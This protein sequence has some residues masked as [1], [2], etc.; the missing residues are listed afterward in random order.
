MEQGILSGKQTPISSLAKRLL[1]GLVIVAVVAFAVQSSPYS[2][3]L[4]TL[5]LNYLATAEYTSLVQKLGYSLQKLLMLL[6]GMIMIVLVWLVMMKFCSSFSLVL[7]LP[8]MSMFFFTELFR[9]TVT[10]VQNSG[11]SLSGILLISLPFTVF[12]AGAFIS[13]KQQ[14]YQPDYILAYFIV[15]WSGDTGAFLIGTLILQL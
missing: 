8:L 6:T 2:F 13:S 12:F 4:L 11:L 15:L 5:L 10:P 9:K 1:T 3:L 14:Q 7:V